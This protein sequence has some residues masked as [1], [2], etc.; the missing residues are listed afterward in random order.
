M[1]GY[2]DS[3]SDHSLNLNPTLILVLILSPYTHPNPNPINAD[4]QR[5]LEAEKAQRVADIGR[6]TH[7]H[8]NLL[9]EANQRIKSLEVRPR[10]LQVREHAVQSCC[11]RLASCSVMSVGEMAPIINM[12]SY[13]LA[14]T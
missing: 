5:K 3:S 1:I 2:S 4:P 11:C 7:T 12:Q 13:E 10:R 8:A 9:A 14:A 6:T